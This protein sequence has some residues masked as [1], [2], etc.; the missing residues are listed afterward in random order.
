MSIA[1]DAPGVE[2]NAPIDPVDQPTGGAGALSTTA[3]TLGTEKVEPESAELKAAQRAR[4]RRKL[5]GSTP[6]LMF[7]VLVLIFLAFSIARPDSF[8]TFLNVRNMVTDTALYL[9]MGIGFT[10]VMVAAGFDLSQGSVL[11]FGQVVAAKVMQGIGGQGGW[12]VFVGFIA[13]IVG[14]AIWGLFNGLVITKMRVPPL[15]TTLGTLGASLGVADLLTQGQDNTPTPDVLTSLSRA[16]PLGLP[17]QVWVALVLAVVAGAYLHTTRYGRRTFVIGSNEE[18]ARRAGIN[19]DRHVIKLY[20][21]SAATAGLAGMM[22]LIN[23]TVTTVG[24]HTTDS[25]IVVTGVALGGIS[26]FGGSGLMV[27]TVIGMFIPTVLTNGLVQ[28][29]VQPFWQQVVIGFILIL[30][31]YL[32]QVKRRRRNQV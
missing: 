7:G 3:N 8:P 13:A 17:W 24:G 18:A 6:L 1:P 23:N 26:L 29:K 19:V 21:I 28:I 32:D 20:M 9:I 31:V 14:G 16:L 5:L 11:V 12:T 15:I 4:L 27:G 22:A 30:A 2:V 10:Y 25:L